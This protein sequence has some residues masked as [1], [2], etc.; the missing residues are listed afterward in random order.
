M[1]IFL[2]SVPQTPRNSMIQ[3]VEPPTLQPKHR[4]FIIIKRCFLSVGKAFREIEKYFSKHTSV[5]LVARASY[6]NGREIENL[7]K[8]SDHILVTNKFK[9]NMSGGLVY[10]LDLKTSEINSFI[11]ECIMGIEKILDL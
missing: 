7:I 10:V 1:S 9:D 5:K 11:G 4:K 6:F 3:M 2:A 8:Y